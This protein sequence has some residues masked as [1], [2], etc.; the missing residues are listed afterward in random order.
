M[1]VSFGRKETT[2][3]RRRGTRIP[4]EQRQVQGPVAKILEKIF[5]KKKNVLLGRFWIRIERG[6]GAQSGGAMS[7]V[8]VCCTQHVSAESHTCF[9]TYNSCQ[10]RPLTRATSLEIFSSQS[11][12]DHTELQNTT[13]A[14]DLHNT[15]NYHIYHIKPCHETNSANSNTTSS[16]PQVHHSSYVLLHQ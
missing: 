16:Q 6:L 14:T 7:I 12:G 8:Y 2:G 3:K 1:L 11:K 13:N 9:R 10:T 4:L 5:E 15:N